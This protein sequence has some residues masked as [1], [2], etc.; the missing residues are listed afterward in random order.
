MKQAIDELKAIPGVV[1]ACLFGAHEGLL[2]SNLPGI[3]KPEKLTAVGKQL[4]KLLTAGRMNF[5]DLNDLSL[6]YD[7]S[8]LIARE[9]RKGLT[10]FVI[11]DPSFNSN[12]LTMSL[13]LLQEEIHEL[14][15]AQLAAPAPSAGPAAA[16]EQAGSDLDPLLD[17]IKA[18][19]SKILGPMA[20][21]IF[22]E[23]R[24]EWAKK[25]ATAD[26]LDALMALVYQEIGDPEKIASFKA[27][28][29]PLL[30]R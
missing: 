19:L 22:D 7:E 18:L 16:V 26:R 15:E 3:F 17:E 4:T 1:G 21:F 28:T 13:N 24:Q 12:L 8:V 9:L 6:H 27:L 11:C 29:A 2:E 30:N 23:I 10:V 14:G 25:G 20:S 5:S